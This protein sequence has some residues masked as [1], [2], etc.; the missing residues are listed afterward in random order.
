MN[1]DPNFPIDLT[2]EET[3]AGFRL[4]TTKLPLGNAEV[5]VAALPVGPSSRIL[6][7]TALPLFP[8][9]SKTGYLLE[10]YGRD[11]HPMMRGRDKPKWNLVW[12]GTSSTIEHALRRSET[13]LINPHF[14]VMLPPEEVAVQQN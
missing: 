10:V 1:T 9:D 11:T 5:V 4:V 6:K 14:E 12:N 7:A 3:A 8:G 2:P 13:E